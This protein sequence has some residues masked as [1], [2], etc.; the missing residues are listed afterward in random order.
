MHLNKFDQH[1]MYS[2]MLVL[3]KEKVDLGWFLLP[4]L[5]LAFK[6]NHG[7]LIWIQGWK[8]IHC[9]VGIQLSSPFDYRASLVAYTSEK[10]TS[11]GIKKKENEL[12]E[13]DDD[14]DFEIN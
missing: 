4:E 5:K 10:V 11:W 2:T 6:I 1:G 13:S 8:Y 14:D 12:I 7:H 9:N 3:T